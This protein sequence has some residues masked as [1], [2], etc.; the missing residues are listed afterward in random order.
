MTPNNDTPYSWLWLD[1]RV[2]PMV[3]SVPA[4]PDRYVPQ[5]IDLSTHN[6]AM[7]RVTRNRIRGRRISAGRPELSGGGAAGIKQALRSETEI[8]GSL[9]R[10]AWT[11][12]DDAAGVVAMRRRYRIRP[13]SEYLGLSP[14]EPAPAF[15]FPAWDETRARSIGFIDY[16]NFILRFAPT[17]PSEDEMM[18]RFA[19]IG[20]GAQ[21][22]FDAAQLDPATRKEIEAAIGDA[23]KSLQATIDKTTSSVELLGTR[24]FWVPIT[25][26]AARLAPRWEFTAIRRE[27]QY[28]GYAVEADGE[29][30][31]ATKVNVR[32]LNL[33]TH[34]VT[35]VEVWVR[36]S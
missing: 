27:A 1:L 14:S 2:E 6:F 22:S 35:A 9:G 30:L 29:P 24:C 21:R 31:D 12:P 25:S 16:L 13:S 26:C 4:P 8:V 10:T 23:Q 33:F 28:T 34:A 11:G 15:I 36:L 18:K 19:L 17:V 3:V 7:Y 20:I 5:W 32:Q